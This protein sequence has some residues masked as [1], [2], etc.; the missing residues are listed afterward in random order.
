MR[1]PEVYTW[2]TGCTPKQQAIKA[3]EEV[4]EVV[5]A[6]KAGSKVLS[7]E[8]IMDVVQALGNLCAM[9]GYSTD[10]LMKAYGR[11]LK[12]NVLRGYC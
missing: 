2:D 10:D 7:L 3:L 11:V 4:S 9:Q 8:E 1:F 12:K 5:E 6:V